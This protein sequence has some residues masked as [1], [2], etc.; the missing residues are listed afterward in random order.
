MLTLSGMA[1]NWLPPLMVQMDK[2]APFPDA[3]GWIA[4]TE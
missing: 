2:T 1:L 4:G 3:C